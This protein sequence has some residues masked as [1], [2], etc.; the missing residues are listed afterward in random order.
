M[1]CADKMI[2]NTIDGLLGRTAALR[3]RQINYDIKVHAHRDPGCFHHAHSFLRPLR[4]QYDYALVV[5]DRDWDG[6]PSQSAEALEAAA[7]TRLKADWGD[8]AASVVISPELES[9]VWSDSPHVESELGW[10]SC[11][12]DLR[13]W[14]EGK[15][16]WSAGAD[17]PADPKKAVEV[18][19]RKA[20][21]PWTA[22]V[23][24]G[25]A[26]KVSVE[27]S[28]DGAFQKLKAILNG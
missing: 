19:T 4:L 27:R 11:F 5:F 2:E 13:G 15:G 20:K 9:W 24:R 21:V 18:A 26:A 28:T 8:K 25:L 17:K 1:L 7:N 16:L 12:G 23:G 6:A 14:L 22:A 10:P 3:I